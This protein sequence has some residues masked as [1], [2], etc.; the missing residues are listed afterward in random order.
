[1]CG[2]YALTN[3]EQIYERFAIQQRLEV[4]TA[5]TNI[6]P[7][8]Y[9]PIVTCDGANML[10]L[11]QWGLVPAWAKDPR[12]GAK[13]INARAET[14]ADKPSF[15]QAFRHQRCLVPA[16]SFYEWAHTGKAKIPF[17]FSLKDH[18]LFAF[19]GL[20]SIWKAPDGATLPTFTI[21]TTQPNN[22]VRTVHDRMPV[23][24]EQRN[25]QLWLDPSITDP[26]A[27]TDLLVPY[28]STD[29]ELHPVAGR[30]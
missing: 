7:G 13:L 12:I 15:K 29:M 18:A 10:S 14:V 11:M 28:A 22:I 26:D 2:R 5:N 30:L 9:A 25:E 23:V 24:M 8:Q 20:Y 3:P 21:I 6:K 1:M 16:T 19:A 27:L 17:S 4:L